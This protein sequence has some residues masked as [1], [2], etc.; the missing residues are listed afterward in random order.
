[1]V[2]KFLCHKMKF[3]HKKYIIMWYNINAEGEIP[4]LI[5]MVI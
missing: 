3:L 4:K 1:M 5:F 2:Y